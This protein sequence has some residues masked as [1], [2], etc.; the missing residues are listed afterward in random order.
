MN[1][2]PPGFT[3]YLMLIVI[4]GLAGVVNTLRSYAS[5]GTGQ[6]LLI[7]ALEGASALFVTVISFLILHFLLPAILGVSLPALGSIGLAGAIA[8]IGLRQSIRLALR[9]ANNATKD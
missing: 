9:M 5:K 8:H 4:G 3:E 6:A 1:I 7:G 2:E